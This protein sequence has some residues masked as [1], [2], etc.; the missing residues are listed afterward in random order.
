M[1]ERENLQPAASLWAYRRSKAE[2]ES[3]D[4]ECNCKQEFP[5]WPAEMLPLHGLHNKESNE[6]IYVVS[7]L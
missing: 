3:G 1:S 6:T 4:L 7:Q 2:R 5:K